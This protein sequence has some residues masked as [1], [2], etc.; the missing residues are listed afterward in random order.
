MATTTFVTASPSWQT[1]LAQSVLI[2]PGNFNSNIN[3][4]HG[5]IA[6]SNEQWLFTP[7]FSLV[8]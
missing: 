6:Q 2:A 1:R 8:K 4:F 3:Y 5:I 7:A